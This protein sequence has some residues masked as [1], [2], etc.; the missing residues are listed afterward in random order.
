[1][2]DIQKKI[3]EALRKALQFETIEKLQEYGD[4]LG[5]HIE[6]V[7]DLREDWCNAVEELR[8]SDSDQFFRRTLI[9]TLFAMIE[10]AVFALKQLILEEHRMEKVNLSPAEYAVLSEESYNL[11]ESGVLRVLDNYLRLKANIKFTLPFYARALGMLFKFEP[12]L[13]KEPRWGSL[14]RAINKRNQLMHPKSQEDLVVGDHDL[15][16][17]LSAASWFIEQ[18]DQLDR[19]A[20]ERLVRLISDAESGESSGSNL[21]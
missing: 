9:R 5:R 18:L 6:L 10:G 11:K 19:I 1:M 12:P 8:I 7:E 4:R 2:K 13:D 16:D 20:F 14:C 21:E 15:E 17:A 3:D